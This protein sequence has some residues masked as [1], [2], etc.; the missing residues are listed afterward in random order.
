MDIIKT[1]KISIIKYLMMYIIYQSIFE[2][3]YLYIT[4]LILYLTL[5]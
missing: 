4:L 1:I 2:Y 3:K 5:S